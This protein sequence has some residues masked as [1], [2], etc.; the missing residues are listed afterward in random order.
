MATPEPEMTSAEE[1][2]YCTVHPDRET[3]L[4][5]NK[6]GRLMCVDCAVRTPV[7]YRCKECVRGI[8]D[9]Y[10]NAAQSDYI[11]IVGVCG[12]LGLLAGAI[13]QTLH[14]GLLFAIILGLPLGGGIAEVTLW[15]I[16]RR[17]GRQFTEVAAVAT[18]VGGLIGALV[19]SRLSFALLLRDIGTLIFIALLVIAVYGRFKMRG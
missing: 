9:K 5:C 13:I 15:G 14:L 17:R 10:F 7:G 2:A 8:Q 1:M 16:Q 11:I 18:A 6:C 12:G 3:G 4:R 19:A